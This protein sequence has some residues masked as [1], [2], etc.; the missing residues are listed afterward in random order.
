[1]RILIIE[2]NPALAQ[3]VTKGLQELG[4]AV[5]TALTGFEG[6]DLAATEP[7]D[8]ILLD[9]M[10][11]DRDGTD[12]ARGLRRRGIATPILMLTAL[13]ATTDK[14]AGLD[15]GADDYLTKPFE[16]DELA[17]RVRALLRRG[18]PSDAVTIEVGDVH[19]DLLKRRVTRA[20]RA[21]DLTAKEFALLEFLLRNPDRVLTR[22]LIAEKVWDLN[23]EP[24]SNVI[25]V[26][27]SQLRRKLERDDLP[28]LIHTVIGSGYRFGEGE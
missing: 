6:E 12:V 25:D 2:D 9:V 15:A 7:Y 16:F 4:Y 10:L 21:I 19:M 3:A 24:G 26:Y 5:D 23:F 14:V 11:P 22:T 8:L 13:S 1:M 17:A 18:E 28:K 20:G 27:V